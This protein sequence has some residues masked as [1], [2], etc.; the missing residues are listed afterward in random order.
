MLGALVEKPCVPD[1]FLRR[2][3]AQIRVDSPRRSYVVRQ[4]VPEMDDARAKGL[5]HG[6]TVIRSVPACHAAF[7]PKAPGGLE[8][9]DIHG[10]V[11]TRS[12]SI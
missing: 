9:E 2:Q 6:G 12:D 1:T 7:Q 11:S 10:M 3:Q 4:S 8:C 5:C